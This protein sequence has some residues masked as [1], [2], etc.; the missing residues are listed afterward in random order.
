MEGGERGGG[1][2]LTTFPEQWGPACNT[3]QLMPLHP[4]LEQVF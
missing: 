3:F 2:S 4:I 1:R